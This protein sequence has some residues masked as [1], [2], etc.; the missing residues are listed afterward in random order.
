MAGLIKPRHIQD[1]VEIDHRFLKFI[2]IFPLRGIK[3]VIEV[4]AC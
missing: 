2:T 3:A 1:T 4:F